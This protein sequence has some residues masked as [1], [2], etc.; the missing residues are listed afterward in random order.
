MSFLSDI[1]YSSHLYFPVFILDGHHLIYLLTLLKHD[2][3]N[4]FVRWT[5]VLAGSHH[6]L[7]QRTG[8]EKLDSLLF[9]PSHA[10]HQHISEAFGITSF[11]FLFTVH[12]KYSFWE[13]GLWLGKFY[14][15]VFVK[16]GFFDSSFIAG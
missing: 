13:R 6:D 2:F 8:V 10:T 16:V 14:I 4:Y 3:M 12:Q 5:G 1:R 7:Y 9:F 15:W 11:S